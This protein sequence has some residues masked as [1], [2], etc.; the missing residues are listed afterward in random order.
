MVTIIHP[1]RGRPQQ[2]FETGK[3]WIEKSGIEE[4]EI[5]YILSLDTDDH[6]LWNYSR[7]FPTLNYSVFI[8]PNRSAIDAINVVAQWYVKHRGKPGDFLVVISDDFE[9]K[10]GWANVIQVIMSG[11]TDWILK[12]VDGIQDW[13]I[14]LPIMDWTYFKRFGYVYHPDYPHAWSD[15]EMTCVAELTG[16]KVIAAMIF[17]HNHYEVGGIKD[18]ISERADSHFEEGKKIFINRLSRKF[19]LPASEIVGTMTE[20]YYT[21]LA[22]KA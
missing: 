4:T 7:K 19:D 18:T 13:V 20:N 2:A 5:E 6:E 16:R 21:R 11:E 9:C 12:T 1:S 8:H 15:T 22:N 3:T 10:E 14:V 17:K